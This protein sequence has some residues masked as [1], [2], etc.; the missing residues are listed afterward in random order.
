MHSAPSRGVFF[1]TLACDPCQ[2]KSRG[3]ALERPDFRRLH[4]HDLFSW[5]RCRTCQLILSSL[6]PATQVHRGHS[7]RPP[8]PP[9]SCEKPPGPV[10][11]RFCAPSSLMYMFLRAI[12]LRSWVLPSNLGVSECRPGKG[13]GVRHCPF[14]VLLSRS[15]RVCLS[16]GAFVLPNWTTCHAPL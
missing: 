11:A 2:A 9:C 10:R 1:L 14:S 12:S 4:W 8:D 7:G 13:E 16:T 6:P 15:T 3:R 5:S